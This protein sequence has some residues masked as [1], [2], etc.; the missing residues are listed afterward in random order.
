MDLELDSL[1]VIW[2]EVATGD[3]TTLVGCCYRPPDR[4]VSFWTELESNLER[5]CSG[6][7]EMTVLVGDFNVDFTETA[8]STARPLEEILT[9]FNLRNFVTSPTRVTSSSAST[10]DLLLTTGTIDGACE[11]VFVDIS[12]HY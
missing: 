9:R 6:R 11:T 10:L 3:G 1:E 8:S 12:T 5:A 2:L 4:P 7:Q